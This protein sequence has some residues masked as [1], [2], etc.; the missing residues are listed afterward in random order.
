MQTLKLN[1]DEIKNATIVRGVGCNEC[2]RTG[3]R[4]RMGIYEI[5]MWTTR[6][7]G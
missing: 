1:P 6:C 5:S 4:G 2:S 7:D 3:Y